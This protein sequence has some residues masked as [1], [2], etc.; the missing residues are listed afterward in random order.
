MVLGVLAAIVWKDFINFSQSDVHD[1]DA[2]VV[3]IA[4]TRFQK[5]SGASKIPKTIE[6]PFLEI[7]YNFGGE[8]FLRKISVEQF[9]LS[10]KKSGDFIKISVFKHSPGKITEVEGIANYGSRAIF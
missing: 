10:D 4:Y 8:D 5:K 7:R 9:F 2:V 3:D 1:V 6:K